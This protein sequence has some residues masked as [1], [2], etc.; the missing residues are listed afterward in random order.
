MPP[1]RLLLDRHLGKSVRELLVQHKLD[2]EDTFHRKWEQ[3]TDEEIIA[4][5]TRED[6]VVVTHD[7]G[8]LRPD[9]FPVCSHS[10]ILRLANR[11]P[12]TWVKA[13]QR[14]IA[15]SQL[16]RV[17]HAVCQLYEDRAIVDSHNE[18]VV[19]AGE[20]LQPI[21]ASPRQP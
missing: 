8:Y 14:L 7:S 11:R 6:R 1:I 10:G 5:A 21:I 9:R 17:S 19:L 16:T 18:S 12:S 4:Y 15:S 2:V 3:M 20:A 13:L